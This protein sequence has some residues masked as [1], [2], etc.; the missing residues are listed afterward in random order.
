MEQ[1]LINKLKQN[2]LDEIDKDMIA[3]RVKNASIKIMDECSN[4][5]DRINALLEEYSVEAKL[6][7]ISCVLLSQVKAFHRSDG[8]SDVAF[9][10]GT[11]PNIEQMFDHEKGGLSR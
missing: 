2:N 5:V 3:A 1:S 6:A 9:I 10:V 7:G 8:E 4:S 11:T